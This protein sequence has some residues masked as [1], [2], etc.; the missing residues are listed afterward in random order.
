MFHLAVFRAWSWGTLRGEER[1]NEG[2]SVLT[3]LDHLVASFLEQRGDPGA[4]CP[5]VDAAE[6]AKPYEPRCAGAA[7]PLLPS[8]PTTAE[9]C[10]AAEEGARADLMDDDEEGYSS[11]SEGP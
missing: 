2:G 11:C 4:G 5:F 1:P 3:C 9:E 7:K 6:K 10:A 8:S